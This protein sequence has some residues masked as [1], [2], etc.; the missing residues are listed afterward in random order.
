ME[1]I[2]EKKENLKKVYGYVR[3]SRDED[4]EQA[5][6][7]NQKQIIRTYAKNNGYILVKIF[8]DDNVSGMTFDRE[9]L[10]ELKEVIENGN[11]DIL[12]VKDLSRIGRHKAYSALFME[13]LR[14]KKIKVISIAENLDNM[15]ENN[16][17]LIGFKQILN[18]QYAKDISRK[19]RA[20]FHQKQKEGLVIVPP[21]GY[22]KNNQTNKIEIDEECAGVV[23]KIFSLY[24]GGFG[25]KKIAQQLTEEKVHTPSWH[26][27]QKS[28]KVYHAG[29][30]WIGQDIWSD[31]TIARILSN[32]AYIGT[33][34]CH[35]T[36]RS[37]IY[38]TRGLIP[39]DE[40]IIH[41]NFYPPIIDEEVWEKTKAIKKNRTRGHVRASGN[42]KI[43]KYAGLLICKDCGSGFVAKKR[44]WNG[45]ERIEYICNAYHRFGKTV[46]T[47]H[48]I[49]EEELDNILCGFLERLKETCEENLNRADKFITKWNSKKRN[50]DKSID[51]I[52]REIFSL[53][54]EVKAYAKQLAKQ[55]I[56][57]ELFQELTQETKEKIDILENQID[58]FQEVKKISKNA[59]AGLL[60]SKEII[61]KIIEE[62]DLVSADLQ[63]L[64]DKIIVHQSCTG[65]LELDIR[66]N[67]PFK[68][69]SELKSTF[70]VI[71]EQSS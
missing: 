55:L 13:E 9:G 51:K 2:I 3:L 4:K 32:E 62:K 49:R 39:K 31:R 59:K 63:M 12:L 69:H 37:V 47:P 64:V 7:E 57:E 54:T 29:K 21:F 58:T 34:K 15:D 38:K 50:Y 52:Q 24:I 65:E 30:K 48:R 42:S 18:E 22:E 35:T 6:L 36:T 19:I 26:Q 1:K 46:C 44:K 71:E 14:S 11:I 68:L 70:T 40:Q 61:D 28:G 67:T 43:H 16:D 10:N 27:F 66:V 53:K 17:I 23:K 45:I 20:A 56:N 60:K 5:S 8:E 41:E 33:L 25:Y